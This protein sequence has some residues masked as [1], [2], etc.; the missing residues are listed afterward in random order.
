V[1]LTPARPTIDRISAISGG[2]VSSESDELRLVIVTQRA[3]FTLTPW[4]G[5]IRMV[6]DCSPKLT[7]DEVDGICKEVRY[8]I[9]GTLAA[10][11]GR[12]LKISHFFIISNGFRTLLGNFA[13]RVVAA[14]RALS[15]QPNQSTGHNCNYNEIEPRPSVFHRPLNLYSSTIMQDNTLPVRR[16]SA[17]QRY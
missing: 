10:P 12:N 8:G 6:V 2:T 13:S 9:I 11:V 3:T 1:K 5:N 4:N 15:K 14:P 17:G 7:Q 16:A